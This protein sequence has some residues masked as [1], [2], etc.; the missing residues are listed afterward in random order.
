VYPG[1]FRYHRAATLEDAVVRLAKA[2]GEARILAGGQTLITAMK[3]RL[4]APGELVDIGFVPGLSF[5]E[6]DREF[7]RF[8][9]LVRHRD[10]E[11]A[12]V[13]RG[14]EILHDAA[15]VIA[16]VQVRNRGTLCGSLAQAEPGGDWAPVML[17]LG[18]QLEVIGTGGRRTVPV[19]KFYLDFFTTDLGHDEVLRELRIPFTARNRTGAYLALKRRTGD[20]AAASVAVNLSLNERGICVAAGIGLGNVGP[21]PL[22][23]EEA[24]RALAG[25]DPTDEDVVRAAAAHAMSAAQ[26]GSDNYG[27]ADYKRE[28]VGVLLRRALDIAVRRHRGEV[29]AAQDHV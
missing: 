18:A 3:T 9:A 16:D 19:R 6:R 1:R 5:I 12:T 11:L 17:A 8:G 23:A 10:V 2:S 25:N 22:V 20:F 28:V 13:D 26:P 27:S 4:V 15:G 14:L 21:M 7:L 24:E 29:I